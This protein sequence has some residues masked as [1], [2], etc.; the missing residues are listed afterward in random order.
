MINKLYQKGWY[1]WLLAAGFIFI[2]GS[3]F[4]L[5]Q[6]HR[7]YEASENERF[8]TFALEQS[9]LEIISKMYGLRNQLKVQLEALTQQTEPH[10]REALQRHLNITRKSIVEKGQQLRALETD[11]ERAGILQRQLAVLNEGLAEQLYFQSLVNDFD[12]IQAAQR[13][14]YNRILPIQNRADMLLT[15]Y[16]G[17]VLDSFNQVKSDLIDYQQTKSREMTEWIFWVVVWVLTVSVLVFWLVIQARRRGR[18]HAQELSDQVATRTHELELARAELQRALAEQEAIVDSAPDAII[19]TDCHANIVDVNPAVQ[20]LFGYAPQ[21]LLGQNVKVLMPIQARRAHEEHVRQFDA[22]R[23][24]VTNMMGRKGRVEGRHKNGRVFPVEAAIGEIKQS[25]QRGFT[26]LIRDVSRTVE[27]ERA[28]MQQKDI[29]EVL[30]QATNEFMVTRNLRKVAD[31]LLDKVI[32]VTQ[33]EYGFIGEVHYDDEGQPYLK[34]LALTDIAWNEETRALY[35]SYEAKD[36]GLEFTNLDTLFG[37]VLT[38]EY[39]VISNDPDTDP[40][41]R[42][43]PEGHPALNAFLGIPVFYANQLVGMVGLAN[44]PEGYDDSL[45]ELLQPFT[46]N[47][48]ALIYVRRMLSVQERMHEE[49]VNE[50][51]HAE[52][53]SR[54]K[55]EF[56]SSMSH[57]LRTPLNS[58]LGYAQLLDMDPLSDEQLENVREIVQAG[59][60]LLDLINVVLDLS[61]IE[62]GKVQ[63]NCDPV[64]LS[65]VVDESLSLVRSLAESA[66]VA[67]ISPDLPEI[68]VQA[69]RVRF[70]QTLLNLLSN[71]IKYNRSGGEVSLALDESTSQGVSPAMTLW[72]C[73]TGYGIDP[74]KVSQLFEPFNRLG[75]EGGVTEG[76]GV[77][78]AIS[79]ELMTLQGGDLIYRPNTPQGSCFGIC[80]PRAT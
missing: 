3:V 39:V 51:N 78:L 62:A 36:E 11:P 40:R 67:L 23:L 46:Q 35:A 12:A 38:S 24:K 32:A 28:L 37:E 4:S 75:R 61:K 47:Y 13:V 19:K 7:D 56:L 5:Y 66:D 69:D 64:S 42:G 15:E 33:S 14:L 10:R 65:S 44:R 8:N 25:D 16:N 74:D 60:H 73:D 49:I 20:T 6:V 30:W 34:T 45:V 17:R 59:E 72:V 1:E 58:I 48:G 63:L 57:E 55:S 76:T 18:R 68:E 21:E 29:L 9:K 79:K 22:S 43:L 41:A 80:L 71:A 2:M 77:G 31:F 53:A 70:K 52:K 54:A 26:V 50:R 27:I